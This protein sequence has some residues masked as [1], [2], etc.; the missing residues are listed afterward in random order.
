MFAVPIIKVN[1]EKHMYRSC[2]FYE[3]EGLKV[4]IRQIL[5]DCYPKKGLARG[6]G[7]SAGPQGGDDAMLEASLLLC[8]GRKQ[9]RLKGGEP[10][11]CRDYYKMS[12]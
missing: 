2:V 7:N 6:E 11:A 8:K 10:F 5:P 12:S 9:C 4:T 3:L 1:L